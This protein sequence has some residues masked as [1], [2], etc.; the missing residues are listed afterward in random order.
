MSVT[1]YVVGP[2]AAL[3]NNQWEAMTNSL[4]EV[5]EMLKLGG[6]FETYKAVEVRDAQNRRRR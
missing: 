6:K 4:T 5:E 2:K 1:I 3:K